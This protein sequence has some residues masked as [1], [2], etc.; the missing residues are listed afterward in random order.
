VIGA[1]SGE[2]VRW[3]LRFD[4]LDSLDVLGQEGPAE[5]PER[6][7]RALLVALDLGRESRRASRRGALGV[8]VCLGCGRERGDGL[9]VGREPE[10]ELGL[11]RGRKGIS[12]LGR[13]R[14]RSILKAHLAERFD[15]L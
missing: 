5:K 4:G 2:D 7:A 8:V 10:M 15:R 11:D 1:K 6:P 12:C 14:T 9:A 13:G 3:V